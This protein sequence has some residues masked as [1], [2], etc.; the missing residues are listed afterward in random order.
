[1]AAAR[2]LAA[3]GAPKSIGDGQEEEYVYRKQVTSYV[4]KKRD[5]YVS[6]QYEEKTGRRF[7]T[8]TDAASEVIKKAHM[9]SYPIARFNSS[10][11]LY[12]CAHEC[13][14]GSRSTSMRLELNGVA[15]C[16]PLMLS[17]E[18]TRWVCDSD[19]RF[20]GYHPVAHKQHLDT[21][22][23]WKLTLTSQTFKGEPVTIA[24]S[25]DMG[26]FLS[27]LANGSGDQSSASAS[28]KRL[29]SYRV[30]LLSKKELDSCVREPFPTVEIEFVVKYSRKHK[31][32]KLKWCVLHADAKP[33][34]HTLLYTPRWSF[35][36]V[37]H[38]PAFSTVRKPMPCSE[39]SIQSSLPH[40]VR[41]LSHVS[42]LLGR[43]EREFSISTTLSG[44]R[45]VS[46]NGSAMYR[47]GEVTEAFT[48]Y[49]V[50]CSL[51]R[52]AMQQQQPLELV[53]NSSDTTEKML[54]RS[55]NDALLAALRAAYSPAPLPTPAQLMTH[56]AGLPSAPQSV[57]EYVAEGNIAALVHSSLFG[58]SASSGFSDSVRRLMAQTKP[59]A[60]PASIVHP[61]VLDS[62]ILAQFSKGD[63]AS[64]MKNLCVSHGMTNTF[65]AS[66]AS[67][68]ESGPRVLRD[69]ENTVAASIG[70]VSNTD[71]LASFLGE[72][73][74]SCGSMRT[75]VHDRRHLSSSLSPLVLSST[76]PY[77]EAESLGAWH[78]A[79]MAFR[80]SELDRSSAID[81]K[82]GQK[83][84]LAVCYKFGKV[85]GVSNCLLVFVPGLHLGVAFA[86]CLPSEA[87]FSNA[88]KKKADFCSGCGCASVGGGDETTGRMNLRAFVKHLVLASVHDSFPSGTIVSQFVD[89]ELNNAF[90]ATPVIPPNLMAHVSMSS[91][92]LSVSPAKDSRWSEFLCMPEVASA[93]FNRRL[94]PVFPALS[95]VAAG[96]SALEPLS[97]IE[98][99]I[100]DVSGA[101]VVYTP[102]KNGCDRLPESDSLLVYDY[103]LAEE[104]TGMER[105]L[106]WN[107]TDNC[108]RAM[109]V[110]YG[111]EQSVATD[112]VQIAFV[113]ANSQESRSIADMAP[114]LVYLGR[115]YASVE[116]LRV[117]AREL[118]Q[119]LEREASRKKATERRNQLGMHMP[120]DL[121]NASATATSAAAAP[122][123]PL[124]S[125]RIE[126]PMTSQ[127]GNL[128][129]LTVLSLSRLAEEPNVFAK[130]AGSAEPVKAGIGNLLV[131]LAAAG[132]AGTVG[133]GLGR[134]AER[135]H[136]Y[137]DHPYMYPPAYPY[138]GYYYPPPSPR[139]VVV[140][141]PV[142]YY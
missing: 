44:K 126:S 56:T 46:Y 116:S 57:D 78:V 93:L 7:M 16:P 30:A 32:A 142:V 139:P 79:V 21:M 108:F 61:S 48:N 70:L 65:L 27:R 62:A 28:L 94:V 136:Y 91:S 110:A 58:S 112:T 31:V 85:G 26:E 141:R 102:E 25:Y 76:T 3:P 80:K 52:H 84:A 130:R 131:P 97:A 39:Q 121:K 33:D 92:K 15:D 127:P 118:M 104:R 106:K 19:M 24:G 134:S 99:R 8:T 128:P 71:D 66:S 82:T 23:E 105:G 17:G 1:M 53:L 107:D 47:L 41:F 72:A 109:R 68:T 140:Q 67:A 64:N 138:D 96:A 51:G 123:E 103:I 14:Q 2:V 122:A 90:S 75:E 83:V 74:K 55:G 40:A 6:P 37:R 36:D 42:K 119:L 45:C 69:W 132:I 60:A 5:R 101:I 115:A 89:E 95:S 100:A 10:S 34:V 18:S 88:E 87:L 49:G 86:S 81:S 54:Q 29:L 137:Y 11:A 38:L 43:T 12:R 114:L 135:R 35:T 129:K 13:C 20:H 73:W 9:K 50:L 59:I 125:E 63:L 77:L 98:A 124:P 113:A 133:Y 120:W 111:E 4:A 22:G 117:M